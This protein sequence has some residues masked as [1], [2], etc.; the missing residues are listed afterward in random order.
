KEFLP[1]PIEQLAE[2]IR[3]NGLL[4][5]ILV[6]P[7]P[8]RPGCQL[9]VAGECRY[10]AHLLIGAETIEARIVDMA[11]DDVRIAQIVENVARQ[12]MTPLEEAFAYQRELDRGMTVEALARKLGMKQAWR[13]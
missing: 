1:H 7:D 12:N 5:P 13:I 11:E 2:S 9:I 10:R 4:Q 3:E 8:E 6:R